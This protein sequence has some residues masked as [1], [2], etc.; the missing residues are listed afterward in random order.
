M[1]EEVISSLTHGGTSNK[2]GLSSIAAVP[3]EGV[4]LPGLFALFQQTTPDFE[5]TVTQA[6]I[7]L[8][9]GY[10]WLDVANDFSHLMTLSEAQKNNSPHGPSYIYTVTQEIPGD[11]NSSGHLLR[12]WSRHEWV[13]VTTST[14]GT[15]RLIG[16]INGHGAKLRTTF[17][18]GSQSNGPSKNSLELV[19]ECTER[20]PYLLA[21]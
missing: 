19:W 8:N 2:P 15:I 16:G 6:S 9:A 21:S 17:S 11:A 4:S 5:T 3:V 1:I 18:S 7:T 20:A 10:S 13:L 12:S 14:D